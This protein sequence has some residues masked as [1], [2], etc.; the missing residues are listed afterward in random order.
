MNGIWLS[1]S[2]VGSGDPLI[3]N[4]A[5]YFEETFTP[6][7]TSWF[8]NYDPSQANL[9]TNASL[10]AGMTAHTDPFIRQAYYLTDDTITGAGPVNDWGIEVEN[11][12]AVES[13][14]IANTVWPEKITLNMM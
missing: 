5:G 6:S 3:F 4:K 7:G 1:G 12:W 8:P 13:G 10:M 9:P 14:T 2:G 11:V